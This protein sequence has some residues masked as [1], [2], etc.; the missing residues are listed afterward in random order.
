[1]SPYDIYVMFLSI[2][3]HFLRKN[4]DVFKYNWKTKASKSSF[5]KRTDR[6][7][8]EKLSRKKSEQEIK[9]FFISNFARTENPRGVYIPDL[10][11]EGEEIY[12]NWKKYIESLSYNFKNELNSYFSEQSL[13]DLLSCKNHQHS[14]M[15]KLYLQKKISIETLVIINE[16]LD[17]I[18][19]YDK[20]LIDPLWETLSMKIQKYSPFLS[21]NKDKYIQI[22]KEQ[23]CE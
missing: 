4:Y 18:R 16:I 8:F 7:F 9:E 20:I 11:V 12:I 19:S 17:Y 15:I 6:Y 13:D 3:Q 5:L 22:M 2:K 21:I 1:M 23:L 14:E 10:M